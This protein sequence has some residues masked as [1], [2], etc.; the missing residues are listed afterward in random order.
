MN[1]SEAAMILDD[2]PTPASIASEHGVIGSILMDNEAFDRVADLV[3]DE[4]FYDPVNRAVFAAAASLVMSGKRADLITVMAELDRQGLAG[5]IDLPA[6]LAIE[7]SVPSSR[8]ARQY[9]Q[10]VAE[11]ALARRLQ[12]ATESARGIASD[13]S[14]PVLDRV[15][16][17]QAVLEGVESVRNSSQPRPVDHFI[18]DFLDRLQDLADGKVLPGMPTGIPGYDRMLGGGLKTKKLVIIAARPSIGKSSLAQQIGINLATD[19][20][21]VGVLSM[22]MEELELTNRAAANLGRIDLDH[23]ET[24]KLNDH[25][26]SRV[27]DAVESMRNLPLYF[28]FQPAMTLQ[29][30][31]S[32]ARMLKRKHGIKILVIDY[33]QLMSSPNKTASR[34]HQIEEI[35]RGLKALAGELDLTVVVLSQLNREVEKRTGGRPTLAD[36]KESGAIEEDADVVI[37]MW[38]HAKGEDVNVIGSDVAKNRG[39]RVGDVA[40][41]FE[42]RYQRW[43]EST[44]S[45]AEQKAGKP[46]R[47]AKDF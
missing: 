32:K 18:P 44:Q 30:V 2:E 33:L 10:V 47:Y 9:A 35:S 40:L 25:E 4:D 14:L 16:Q 29:A 34:H 13:Y 38:R 43:T 20:V 28:D 1:L 15:G 27:A 6:L 11:H 26:W 24:G 19:G 46:D 45:L 12:A 31:A 23:I 41:H 17:A 42:G 36:L 8:A 21:P 22:E 5:A 37:L 3:R 39:G 7:H